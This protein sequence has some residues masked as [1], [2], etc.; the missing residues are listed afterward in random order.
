MSGNPYL[1]GSHVTGSEALNGEVVVE[2]PHVTKALT[3][4]N[5]NPSG[6]ALYIH[7][8]SRQDPNVTNYFHFFE[9]PD[10]KDS[11]TLNVKCKEVYVSMSGSVGTGSFLCTAEL[12]GIGSS[13]IYDMTGSGITSKGSQTGSY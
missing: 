10:Y 5:N 11:I 7:F 8:A 13:E 12:T 3:I 6:H 2:F 4:M 9:L 1:T